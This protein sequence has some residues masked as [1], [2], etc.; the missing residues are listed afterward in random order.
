[1]S[2]PQRCKKTAFERGGF[3]EGLMLNDENYK[4]DFDLWRI[5]D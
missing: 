1:M 4:G 2:K 5:L 3:I